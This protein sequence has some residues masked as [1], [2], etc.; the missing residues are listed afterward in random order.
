MYSHE[1]K[2]LIAPVKLVASRSAMAPKYQALEIAPDGLKACSSFGLVDIAAELDVNQT[3]YVD[4]SAF[5]AVVDSLP[6]NEAVRIVLSGTAI[7]WDCGNAN[8]RLARLPTVA[9]MPSLPEYS[10]GDVVADDYDANEFSQALT[11]GGL[12]C[13]PVSV[14]AAS[15]FGVQFDN[16][17]EEARIAATDSVTLSTYTLDPLNG[18]PDRVTLSPPAA[19]LLAD[20]IGRAGRAP[21]VLEF[22]DNT[23]ICRSTVTSC[24]VNKVPPLKVDLSQIL[25]NYT[26]RDH[27]VRL[28]ISRVAKF[29]RQANALAENRRN[30]RVMVGL[31]HGIL[32]MNFN[33]GSADSDEHFLIGS[34]DDVGFAPVV[35]SVPKMA[36]VMSHVTSVVLDYATDGIIILQGGGFDYYISGRATAAEEA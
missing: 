3:V 13:P 11:L 25:S 1:L 35:L 7:E 18:A 36:R 16:G 22:R 10:K 29:V 28:E 26:R 6:D 8:G 34:D 32:S 5:L 19:E 21:Q 4:A 2:R 33:E 24:M 31:Q 30:A 20:V 14:G 27:V 23:V 9:D 12:S 15:M 17:N